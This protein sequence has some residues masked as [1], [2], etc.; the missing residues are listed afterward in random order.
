MLLAMI[1]CEQCYIGCSVFVK[2]LQSS[3]ADVGTRHRQAVSWSVVTFD[4]AY[5]P[6]C[7][8]DVTGICWWG[9]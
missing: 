4:T 8:A 9:F 7:P 5:L 2:R 6:R 1:G 3:F